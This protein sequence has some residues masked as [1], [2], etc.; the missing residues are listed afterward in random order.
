MPESLTTTKQAL[1]DAY[2]FAGQQMRNG[3]ALAVI[4]KSLIER[5]L[6]AE[7]AA[8]AISNLKQAKAKALKNAGHKNMLHGALWCI[9][10]IVVTALS[11]QAAANAGGGRYVLAWGAILFGG[12]QFFRGLIQ[13][14]G[15]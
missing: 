7:T 14:L 15:R 6:D 1:E 3:V 9:G 11:Y 12:I 2:R 5:G 8:I 10:G 4:E 13:S